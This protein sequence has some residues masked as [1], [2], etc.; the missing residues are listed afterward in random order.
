V[1]GMK[2]DPTFLG[3]VQDVNGSTIS[4]SLHSDT[5]PGLTFI[6]GHGYRIGQVGSFIRIPIGY[7]DLFGIISQVGAGSVPANLKEIEPHGHRWMTVQIIGEVYRS[8]SF[9]R[10][11]SQYPTIGDSVHIV[12]DEDLKTIYG[13]PDQPNYLKIG[14]LASSDQI[15]ALIN[16]DKLVTRHSAVV[17]NTGSGKSTTVAGLLA[18]LSDTKKYESARIIVLDIHGEYA[19]ALKDVAT[20]FR[21]NADPSKN[22]EFLY[23]PYWAMTFDE[24]L[25]ITL[26]NL[27]DTNRGPILEKITSLKE[28]ALL[29][30]S[31]DGIN[32]S[33]LTVD[34]P[35]PFSIHKFWFDLHKLLNATHSVGPTEQ[36]PQ[37]ESLLLDKDK[38]PIQLGDAL[39]VIPPRYTPENKAAGSPKIYLSGCN[40]SVRRQ[41]D[42][43]ATKLRDP[44]FDFLFRPGDWMPSEEGEIKQDLD[45]LLKKWIGGPKPVS[46][47]DLS[48]IPSSVL[49]HLIGALLRIIYDSL[50]WGRFLEEGGRE[51]PLLVVLEEAHIYLAS[52]SNNIAAQAVKRIVKEGRKYW[53]GA[54]VVSQRPSEIDST[55]LSQCGTIFAMRLSNQSDRSH[56]IGAVSDNLEG[57]FHMLPSLRTGEAIIVGEAVH[58]P[59]RTIIDPLTKNRRPD[60]RDPVVCTENEVPGGWNKSRGSGNYQEMIYVWRKQNP[61]SPK[62]DQLTKEEKMERNPVVSSNIN[63]IGFDSNNSVLEV[64]FYSGFIYHYFDVPQR[65]YEALMAAASKGEYLNSHIKGHY[66]YARL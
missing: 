56:V 55:I 53:I 46:I 9:N 17:G 39:K 16:I 14:H 57:L 58:L 64:E 45:L 47:L 13:T 8:G 61:R 40:L 30:K 50:F 2:N 54:M 28:A 4:V 38:K 20:V 7:I 22:E 48:G 23:I 19:S 60:S 31:R 26:G 12:T 66:R 11:I 65:E 51:R 49:N 21:V 3:D 62:L 41:I 32:T 18:S 33:T 1:K 10:G 37:T 34:S 36:S 59:M 6:N 15:P 24:L 25:P 42:F 27:D 5:L 44:R 52:G 43:L 29:K 63:S 35:V